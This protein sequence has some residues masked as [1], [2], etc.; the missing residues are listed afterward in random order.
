[1]EQPFI[2]RKLKALDEHRADTERTLDNHTE[3]LK[4]L[5]EQSDLHTQAFVRI[6]A[7][8]NAHTETISE[9]QGDVSAIKA[10]QSDHSELLKGLGHQVKDV[11][12]KMNAQF[13]QSEARFDKI[14]AMLRQILERQGDAS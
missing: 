12:A 2:E 8:L 4:E 9:L 14:E 11:H 3:I 6:E 10:T 7:I 13:Q 1:V 5:S